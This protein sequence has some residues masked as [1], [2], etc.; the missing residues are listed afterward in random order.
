M[1]LQNLFCETP[2]FYCISAHA[3]F[4]SPLSFTAIPPF[5][6]KQPFFCV[7]Q[8]VC[9]AVK[10]LRRDERLIKTPETRA[11]NSNK[12]RAGLVHETDKVVEVDAADLT[13]RCVFS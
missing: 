7:H 4:S 8:I 10:A 11:E 5:F 9:Q 13:C 6:I 2:E 3:P 12:I 1:T